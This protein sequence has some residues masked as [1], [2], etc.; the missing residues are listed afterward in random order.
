MNLYQA[1]QRLFTKSSRRLYGSLAL[2]IILLGLTSGTL[3]PHGTITDTVLITTIA[4]LQVSQI[5]LKYRATY[6]Y[7]KGD[8]PRRMEQFR[9]GF[10][11]VPS[12]EK[13]ASLELITGPCND[14]VKNDYWFS[15]EPPSPKRMVQMIL[16]SSFSTRYYAGKC[17]MIFFAIG[18]VG[19]TI[20]LVA[21]LVAFQLRDVA[22]MS[23]FFAHILLTV[24]VFFL[25]GDFWILSAAYR[26][27]RDAANEV[28]QQAFHLLERNSEIK[29]DQALEIAMSYNTATAQ[30]PPLVAWFYRKHQSEIDEQ[31]LRHYGNFLGLV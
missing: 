23:D 31:F 1:S 8:E 25:T 14:P 30:S 3:Y 21:L 9:S 24:F 13:I 10:G 17:S 20:C 29:D 19:I 27:L 22:R 18:S 28:H 16:E 12:V 2:G 11:R 26:D 4:L 5:W 6:W 15:R 7:T